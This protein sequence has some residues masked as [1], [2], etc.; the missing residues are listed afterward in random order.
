MAQR[1]AYPAVFVIKQK[2]GTHIEIV[3]LVIKGQWVRGCRVNG[4]VPDIQL[5]FED[6]I[7][8]VV[9]FAAITYLKGRWK[10]Q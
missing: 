10:Y 4:A 6:K 3:H 1:E 2:A 5:V 8:E 7:L 9:R